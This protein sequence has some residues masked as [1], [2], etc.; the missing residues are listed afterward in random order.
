MFLTG[1]GRTSFA[2][3]VPKKADAFFGCFIINR[4][5]MVVLAKKNEYVRIHR[6]ILEAVERT[7]KLPEDTK[8]VP[9]E[10]WVKGWL[11]DDEAKIGDTVT[12]KT[13]VGRL[14]TGVL[15][16]E[17]PCYALNYG[18]YVPEILE[19]DQRLRSVLFEGVE[20]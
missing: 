3:I 15:M 4:K 10:M 17:K 8:S 6:N 20:A 13:V 19:I 16:E 18:E 5:G 2:P 14:E 1:W 9:L 11:Q 7:G 12:V